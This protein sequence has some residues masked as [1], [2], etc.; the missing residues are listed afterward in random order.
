MESI[1]N[2]KK[3]VQVLNFLAIKEGGQIGKLKAMKLVWLADRLHLRKYLRTITHDSYFAMKNGP[4]PSRTKDIAEGNEF[5]DEQIK[6]YRDSYIELDSKNPIIISKKEVDTMKFSDS[7]EEIL[8][9]IYNQFGHYSST[10]LVTLSHKFPEWKKYQSNNKKSRIPI[11]DI[12][13]FENPIN[14]SISIFHESDELL[15]LGKDIYL[16]NQAISNAIFG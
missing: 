8:T 10:Q 5:V 15:E 3:I 12:E 6:S 13:F 2:N 16:E 14:N 4:V 9:E 11:K 1:A 7:D